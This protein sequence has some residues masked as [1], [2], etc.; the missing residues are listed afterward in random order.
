VVLLVG[1]PPARVHAEMDAKQVRV[2]V[3][4]LVSEGATKSEAVKRVAKD[5]GLPRSEV[6]EVAHRPHD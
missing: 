6:Y 5:L 2:R 1:P 4:T 3:E